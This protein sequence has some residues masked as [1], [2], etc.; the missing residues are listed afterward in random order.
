MVQHVLKHCPGTFNCRLLKLQLV[1]HQSKY[2]STVLQRKMGLLTWFFLWS[3][4]WTLVLLVF[5][6]GLGKAA[7][8]LATRLI[9]SLYLGRRL[10]EREMHPFP[11]L[12]C[13]IMDCHVAAVTVDMLGGWLQSGG[14]VPLIHACVAGL[15][16]WVTISP[17][18][19]SVSSVSSGSL[20]VPI[21]LSAGD[22]PSGLDAPVGPDQGFQEGAGEDW[23]S[24][25][26][27]GGWADLVLGLVRHSGA[28][29]CDSKIFVKREGFRDGTGGGAGAR[30]GQQVEVGAGAG[31]RFGWD[32]YET[33]L[34]VG[35]LDVRARRCKDKQGVTMA[36]LLEQPEGQPLTWL[37]GNSGILLD[38]RISV[39]ADWTNQPG[40]ALPGNRRRGGDGSGK[41]ERDKWFVLSSVRYHSSPVKAALSEHDVSFL[42]HL[43]LPEGHRQQHPSKS[44]PGSV[45]PPAV[46][47]RPAPPARRS[48]APTLSS[49][50]S[51]DPFW[52]SLDSPEGGR[53]GT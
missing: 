3:I 23:Y 42:T 7:S 30:A 33:G 22:P 12:T 44:R 6:L 21:S 34:A 50:P 36:V 4:K 53:A 24:A 48:S 28:A 32:E 1:A 9:N 16:V 10:R 31:G 13:R 43:L 35:L 18:V 15:E 14:Q 52:Q 39:E 38:G 47:S 11:G 19:S 51:P 25:L 41:G 40:F 46:S 2:H 8:W 26:S 27:E 20:D 37:G 5:L 29:V 17:T 49:Y 45:D